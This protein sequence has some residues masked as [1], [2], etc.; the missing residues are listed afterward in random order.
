MARTQRL[1]HSD[2]Q[3][4]NARQ[5]ILNAIRMSGP[6][7]RI[8]IAAHTRASPATVTAITADLIAAGL[9]EEVTPE[10]PA[11]D[12]KRGRPRVAL[13]IRGEAHLIAGL[14]VSW[15]SISVLITDFEGTELVDYETP[16]GIG[17]QT[18]DDLCRSI[19]AAL[20]DACGQGGLRL[21]QVSGVGVALAGLVDAPRNF[22]HWSS[23]LTERNVD[24]GSALESRLPCPVFI[25]N[26]ANLV[27]KAEHLLGAGRNVDNFVVI[28]I[29]H[30]VGMG[31]VIDDKIYR[32][33]RGCGTEFGHTKVQ[34]EGA[35]CQCGQR[36]CLEAYVGDYALLREA[37]ITNSRSEYSELSDL[38]NAAE[39]GDPV[40]RS[41]LDRAGRMFALG[42]ANVINI[43]DPELIVLSG[44]RLSLDF[45]RSDAVLEQ[46][47]QWIVQVDAPLPEIQVRNWDHQAWARGA[48]AYAIE[49]VSIQSIREM[50]IN[51][52]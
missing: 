7:A 37:N 40:A 33:N 34:L 2:E 41:V 47:R 24:L 12:A 4:G 44:Q 1:S 48:A 5:H 21:D 30:G 6:I 13:K 17:A 46:M 43:F 49:E 3:R 26:D 27:A 11:Q 51:A 45:L 28:T 35:L 29:E 23:S 52:G 25:D 19:V 39:E 32:G 16:L 9:V 10:A 36:G 14:K 31:V 15:N 18:V 50:T 42:L 8:D 22:V 20:Q 38:Y